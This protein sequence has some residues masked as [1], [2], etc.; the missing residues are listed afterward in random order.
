MEW[1]GEE[2]ARRRTSQRLAGGVG[3]P[4]DVRLRPAK[5]W[6]PIAT[7]VAGREGTSLTTTFHV[8]NEAEMP[9]SI[10]VMLSE[11]VRP[12]LGI[13]LGTANT[14]VFH[15]RRGPLQLLLR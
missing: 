3:H 4:G 6:G 13:D 7:K 10:G 15:P 14:V 2:R 9:Y 1:R 11:W 8:I 5:I 12:G